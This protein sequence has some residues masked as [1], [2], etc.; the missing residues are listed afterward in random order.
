MMLAAGFLSSCISHTD[1]IPKDQVLLAAGTMT[2]SELLERLKSRSLKITTLFV[3]NSS[4]KAS[5]MRSNDAITNYR[6]VN[7]QIAVERPARIRLQI[8]KVITLA[9]MVS[10]EKTYRLSIPKEGKFGVGSV[11]AP[12]Q[13]AEF[14]YN[15][16]PSHILD[17]LFV[18][19]EQF[20]GKPG[21][22]A[23]MREDTLP[24]PDGQHSYYVVLFA[25]NGGVPLEEL[26]FD[27]TVGVM[28]V[29]RKKSYLPDGKVESD[30]RYSDYSVINSVPFPKSIVINRPIENY[31]L[32]MKF[33]R[34]E[35]NKA[36]EP[37]YFVL[38]RPDGVI[39]VDLNTGK[40]IK[41]K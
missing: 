21:I 7:A 1:P 18:D 29:V 22:D 39:D 4:M 20:M 19:G 25:K 37:S 38:N 23:V 27:R 34:L 17:A 24:F 10:D 14:P 36:L 11:S 3:R 33:E 13:G 9:E 35:L 12:V 41:P 16:R 5:L 32:D 28:E 15:L 6:E 2:K 8:D 31:K 40:E 30:I 26:W